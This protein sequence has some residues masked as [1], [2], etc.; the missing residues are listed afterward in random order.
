MESPIQPGGTEETEEGRGSCGQNHS[1]HPGI[2]GTHEAGHAEGM[3]ETVD[4]KT[5]NLH[6]T[7]P[8]GPLI[9]SYEK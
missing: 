8:L 7:I 1:T 6:L 3:T 4:P 2:D 5:V 9:F